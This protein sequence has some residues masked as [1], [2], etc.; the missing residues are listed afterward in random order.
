MI[1][2][3]SAGHT[4]LSFSPSLYIRWSTRPK[5]TKC[6]RHPP[7]HVYIHTSPLNE[8]SR[9]IPS[10]TSFG[11]FYTWEQCTY[12]CLFCLYHHPYATCFIASF[13][14][15]DLLRP[16]FPFLLNFAA[17]WYHTLPFDHNTMSHP[18]IRCRRCRTGASKVRPFRLNL[19]IHWTSVLFLV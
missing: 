4:F 5:R 19:P 13:S 8:S 10:H 15:A 6:I 16:S 1:L 14:H 11:T 2:P 3:I 17:E 9:M 18:C 12:L 7:L